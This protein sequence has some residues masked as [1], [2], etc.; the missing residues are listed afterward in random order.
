MR[1]G[2]YFLLINRQTD[3]VSVGMPPAFE[4]SRETSSLVG[5]LFYP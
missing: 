1:F 3:K 4:M 5:Q 2:N